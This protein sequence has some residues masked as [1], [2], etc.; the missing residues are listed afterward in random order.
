VDEAVEEARQ[1]VRVA[2]HEPESFIRLAD[3]LILKGQTEEAQRA[4]R[5]ALA[6]RDDSIDALVG[7]GWTYIENKRFSDAKQLFARALEIDP[8]LGN[9]YFYMGYVCRLMGD[10]EESNRYC[11]GALDHDR[12][13][14]PSRRLMADNFDSLGQT[15]KAAEIRRTL[16]AL[17]ELKGAFAPNQVWQPRLPST[18]N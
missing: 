1:A 5:S 7:L 12:D 3:M 9:L 13:M 6:N 15:A 18:R 17:S 11:Q 10:Y 16:P 8:G 4:Y 14:V 2:P